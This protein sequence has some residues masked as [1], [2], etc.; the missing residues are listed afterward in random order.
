[1]PANGAPPAGPDLINALK[2]TAELN[3]QKSSDAFNINDFMKSLEAGDADLIKLD[4]KARELV[5]QQ[6]IQVMRGL[7]FVLIAL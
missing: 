5:M 2:N 1:M 6:M 4:A 7:Q 3:S